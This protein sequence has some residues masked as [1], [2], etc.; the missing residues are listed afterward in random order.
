MKEL[1]WFRACIFGGSVIDCGCR[2]VIGVRNMGAMV[3]Y[4]VGMRTVERINALILV[5]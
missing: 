4:K 2:V 1:V 3:L 5:R